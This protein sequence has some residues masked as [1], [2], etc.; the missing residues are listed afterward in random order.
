M[1]VDNITITSLL[2]FANNC[3]VSLL[4]TVSLL[5]LAV[6]L[7]PVV[8]RLSQFIVACSRLSGVLPLGRVRSMPFVFHLI[9]CFLWLC[10]SFDSIEF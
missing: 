5:S 8:V 2:L 9:F 7:L 10:F 3:P 6:A 1:A 4:V